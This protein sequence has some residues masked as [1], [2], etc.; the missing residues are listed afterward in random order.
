MNYEKE[1]ITGIWWTGG[2]YSNG[3]QYKNMMY[4]KYVDE[5]QEKAAVWRTEI[6][7]IKELM[8][9]Y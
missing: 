1:N 8:N 4:M 7:N 3:D 5:E 2:K 6:D 9:D